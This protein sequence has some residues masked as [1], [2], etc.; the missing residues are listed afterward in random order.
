MSDPNTNA[1]RSGNGTLFFI[2]GALVVAVGVLYWIFSGGTAPATSGA[3]APAD[4]NITIEN[5]SAPAATEPADTQ[6]AA[7]T[8]P[9]PAAN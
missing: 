8:E 4:T 6:P 7:G 9:A 1:Q 5:S 3:P 2:V